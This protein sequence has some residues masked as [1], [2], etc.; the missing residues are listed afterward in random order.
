M[1][2]KISEPFPEW[3]DTRVIAFELRNIRLILSDICD[4]MHDAYAQYE[5]DRQ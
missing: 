2:R 3:S 1:V 4:S 5:R